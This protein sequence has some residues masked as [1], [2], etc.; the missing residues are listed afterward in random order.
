MSLAGPPW[1]ISIAWQSLGT[2][3]ARGYWRQLLVLGPRRVKC[4]MSCLVYTTY[5]LTF[6]MNGKTSEH[7][8]YNVQ[9]NKWMPQRARYV[10]GFPLP[11]SRQHLSHDDFWG[12][13]ENIIRTVLCATVVCS[14]AH[15]WAVLEL[16][17][18][19]FRF[20]HTQLYFTT[21]VVAKNRHI[22]H[23]VS[24]LN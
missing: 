9:M 23:T 21:D 6:N 16:D 15:M 5:M 13:R 3:C 2:R 10:N 19:C 7:I 24:K 20:T 18:C 12:L 14:V 11:S 1:S 17:E 8:K 22:I 4:H